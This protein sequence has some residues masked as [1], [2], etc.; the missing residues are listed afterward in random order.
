MRLVFL[1]PPGSGKGTQAKL[2]REVYPLVHISTGDMIRE[3]MAAATP[4]GLKAKPYYDRGELVPDA[5][6]IEMVLERL[7]DPD[8]RA[9]FVLDGF[10]RTELQAS[11][12]DERLAAQAM[13]LN[14]AVLLVVED[15]EIVRRLSGRRICSDCQQAYHVLFLPPNVQDRCD[16]CGGR[17]VQRE[18]DRPEAIRMRLGVFHHQTAEVGR[19]YRARGLLRVVPGMGPVAEVQRRIRDAITGEGERM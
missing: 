17:L 15:D 4:T 7:A 13:P 12:L 8:C 9:G 5:I 6:I 11:A 14:A 18:D 10:P 1:G 16:R 2:L 19:Y 3:R